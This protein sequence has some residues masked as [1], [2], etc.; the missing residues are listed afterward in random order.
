MG[1]KS[2]SD[3]TKACYCANGKCDV[4]DGKQLC[5]CN[6]GF[7]NYSEEECRACNCGPGTNCVFQYN[8]YGKSKICLC[9]PGFHEKNGKCVGK[10]CSTESECEYPFKCL[11]QGDGEERFCALESCAI[12]DNCEYPLECVDLGDK[13]GKVCKRKLCSEESD[14]KY[15]LTCVDLGDRDG[16]KCAYESCTEEKDYCEFPLKCI[17]NGNGEHVCARQNC[18]VNDDCEYPLKCVD[19]GDGDGRVCT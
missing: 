13:G 3:T 10:S 7:G 8:R 16:K 12:G 19:Y 18:T 4:E 17:A 14:C 9:K 6:P 5:K 11:D 1:Q 2:S 15:P